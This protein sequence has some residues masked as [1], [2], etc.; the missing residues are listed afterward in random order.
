MH[1]L[2][3]VWVVISASEAQSRLVE[4]IDSGNLAEAVGFSSALNGL[5]NKMKSFVQQ[6]GGG[7]PIY[8][9]ER[10]V[11]QIS[12]STAEQL[13]MIIKGYSE[14]L[15]NKIAVGI[16]LTMEEASR[17]AQTS[18]HTGNIELYD[19]ESR[20]DYEEVIKSGMKPRRWKSNVVL[21]PNIFDPTVP[22]A[23]PYASSVE[24]TDS[25]IPTLEEALENEAKL[26]QAIQ[27]QIGGNQ[28]QQQEQ[29]EQQQQQQPRDLLESLNGGPVEG[30]EPQVQS[31]EPEAAPENIENE[32]TSEIEE[33]EESTADDKIAMQLDKIKGQIPQIMGLAQKDPKAFKQTMNMI[34]KLIQLAHNRSRSTKK[35][36]TR[37][38]I[39]DLIKSINHRASG[40]PSAGGHR[41]PVG[42][43]LGRY[44][45][46]L[47]EG[48]EKWREMSSG[49]TKDKDGSP[50]SIKESNEQAN[51]NQREV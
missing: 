41:F 16:G 43:R 5:I 42:T 50:I 25:S 34:N 26:V 51:N 20:Y 44:K 13:P 47:V 33:A 22:D 40:R 39:E 24:E 19:P 31:Q 9:Y 23:E 11:M 2:G 48:K 18:R 7:M 49:I 21:P 37:E 45:K 29:Q 8:L 10:I 15:N 36:E 35:S 14:A 27:G 17:A 38:R 46:V 30:H 12:T 28:M 6:Y 1:N 32:L 4:L 3:T